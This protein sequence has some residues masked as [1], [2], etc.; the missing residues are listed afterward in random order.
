MASAR[1]EFG[2]IRK[3]A[4]GRH[5]A[6]YTGPDLPRHVA[7]TTFQAVTITLAGQQ[8]TAQPRLD[9]D[10]AGIINKIPDLAGHQNRAPVWKSE[11][12]PKGFRMRA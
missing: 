10:T 12:Q 1:R 8:V 4:S 7:P 5:Q 11:G 6:V 3:L 9:D 2:S